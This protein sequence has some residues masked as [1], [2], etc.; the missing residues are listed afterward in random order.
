MPNGEVT[1]PSSGWL[2][3]PVPSTVAPPLGELLRTRL[4]L[5]AELARLGDA[6]LVERDVAA[7]GGLHGRQ[8]G[9]PLRGERG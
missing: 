5:R 1:T 4:D 3:L 6:G 9:G 7:L 2:K 8:R